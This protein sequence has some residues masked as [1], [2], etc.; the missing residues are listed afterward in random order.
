MIHRADADFWNDYHA[1][2]AAIR[3]LADK[4]FALVKQYP[5]RHP[6]LQLKGIGQRGD[7]EVW[8][9]LVWL[10][11]RALAFKTPNEYVWFWI[12]AHNVYDAIDW[13]QCELIERVPGKVSGRPIVRGTRNGR[14]H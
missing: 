11:Y 10:K 13:T 5:H 14:Q 6:S 9:A 1:L 4:Q 2:P 7:R 3:A 8:P 12:G